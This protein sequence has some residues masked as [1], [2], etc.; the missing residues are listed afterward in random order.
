LVQNETR[1]K[2]EETNII[3]RNLKYS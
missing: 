1:N 3:V 2:H